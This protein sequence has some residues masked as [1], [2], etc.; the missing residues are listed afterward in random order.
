[1]Q[2]HNLGSN[3]TPITYETFAAWKAKR[4]ALESQQAEKERLEKEAAYK[5]SR[6]GAK[7]GITFSGREMFEFSPEMALSTDAEEGGYDVYDREDSDHEE[8]ENGTKVNGS[9]KDWG[10]CNSSGNSSSKI[11]DYDEIL[12]NAKKKQHTPS[13]QQTSK[14]KD[15]EGE[16][17]KEKTTKTE[18]D[19]N[20][21]NVEVDDEL[22]DEEGLEGLDLEE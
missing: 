20:K 3:L 12:N 22:F 18:N 13:P 17:L 9:T 16:E 8:E 15:D 7:V 21:E 2:R 1:M 6:E 11:K 19:S 14:R 5:R 4:K 10:N